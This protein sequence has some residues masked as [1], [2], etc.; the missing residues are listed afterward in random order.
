MELE[1]RGI[2][3][4][5]RSYVGLRKT[6]EGATYDVYRARIEGD[7]KD[8]AVILKKAAHP[9]SNPFAENEARVLVH[10]NNELARAKT[11]IQLMY[12]QLIEHF[13]VDGHAVVVTDC[14]VDFY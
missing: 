6:H 5:K 9:D 11:P 13:E 1:A 3:S 12:P 14:A 7:V 10:I 8:R 4:P 2:R